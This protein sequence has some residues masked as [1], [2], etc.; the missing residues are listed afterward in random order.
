[1]PVST[2]CP[3]TSEICVIGDIRGDEDQLLPSCIAQLF[4]IGQTLP[5]FVND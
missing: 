1:M 4:C 2:G 5:F 3:L